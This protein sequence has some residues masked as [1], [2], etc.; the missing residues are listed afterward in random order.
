MIRNGKKGVLVSYGGILPDEIREDDG[1]L[2][3]VYEYAQDQV[4]HEYAE[5]KWPDLYLDGLYA[6]GLV[7][8]WLTLDDTY[9]IINDDG[10]EILNLN[11]EYDNE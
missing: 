7:I 5:N 4:I 1:L 11:G 9:G 10:Y 3:L 6:P 8:E 2:S